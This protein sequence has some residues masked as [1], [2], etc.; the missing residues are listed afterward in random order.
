MLSSFRFLLPVVFLLPLACSPK[1]DP[2]ASGQQAS[3]QS[4]PKPAVSEEAKKAVVR[5]Y[6]A[7]VHASYSDAL[8]GAIA[9]DN[10]VE[11]FLK[12][13]TAES[14]KAAKDA[15]LAS[16][17]PYLQTEV[18]RF[19]NGPI[20]DAN[21]P[22]GFLNAWPMDESFIDYTK[23]N[24][25]SGIIMNPEKFKEITVQLLVG[26]NAKDSETSITTG[27][28]AVEYLLWGQDFNA[29][30]PGKRPHTD[31]VA[32]NPTAARRGA[33]LRICS[34]LIVEQLQS[35]VAAWAP[36]QAGNYRSTFVSAPAD[37]SLSKILLGMGSLSG[38]ELAGERMTVAY[39]SKEQEDEHSCFSD[40]T[41]ADH[42]Y[43]DIGIQNIY[44]GRYQKTDGT[45][46]QGAS[47]KSLIETVN[48]DLAVALDQQFT[49]SIEAI[50]AIPHP[51]DQAILG[52]D[53]VPGRLA[54]KK[55]IESLRD[56]TT[57]IAEAAGALGLKINLE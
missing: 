45:I 12:R 18:F 16:R 31:Y 25:K 4:A 33:Y 50:K 41:P 20:D 39:E 10:A 14:F 2:S 44:L 13:P 38:A 8:Q 46:L 30:G 48:P 3:E 42:L 15:W 21:G 55:A 32:S 1:N 49:A 22:E 27:Y 26:M 11:A 23:D 40:N 19:Y 37:E 36:D 5:Q 7:I 9:L 47:L 34:R 51:F 17:P 52:E 24:P 6:A 29:D 53:S 28:H 43:D 56:Q 54:I 57:S 35:L